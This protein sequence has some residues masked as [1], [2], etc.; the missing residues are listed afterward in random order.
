MR[1]GRGD[2]SGPRA[3]NHGASMENK[4]RRLLTRI[5]ALEN[6][7]RAG[8]H[9]QETR[10]FYQPDGKRVKFDAKVIRAIRTR[11]RRLQANA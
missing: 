11:Q 5:T 10:I 2:S 7:L 6:D 1:P 8:L 4:I 9:E 3:L